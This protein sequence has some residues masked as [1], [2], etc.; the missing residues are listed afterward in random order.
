MGV[1]VVYMQMQLP[2]V[3]EAVGAAEQAQQDSKVKVKEQMR[4]VDMAVT[5]QPHL[6]PVH[7]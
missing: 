3:A 2:V 5:V 6:F 1:P 4:L 7:L